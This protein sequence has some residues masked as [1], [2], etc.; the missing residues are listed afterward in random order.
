MKAGLLAAHRRD[1]LVGGLE[2]LARILRLAV[3]ARL[4]QP[5]RCF[6]KSL[7]AETAIL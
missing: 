2:T 1:I 5:I 4:R 7:V 6:V 3:V